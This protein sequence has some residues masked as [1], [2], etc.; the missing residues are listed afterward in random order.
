MRKGLMIVAGLFLVVGLATANELPGYGP[1]AP[2][3][4]PDRPQDLYQGDLGAEMGLGCS[5]PTGNSGGPNDCAVG[6]TCDLAPPFC[7]S[8]HYYYVFTTS[9]YCTALS[10]VCWMGGF[11]PGAEFARQPGMDWSWGGHT[12]AISPPVQVNSGYFFFGHNQPQTNCGMRWGLDTSSPSAQ[13]SFIRAPACGAYAWTL[14]D[15]LG[16]PGNWC[17]SATVDATSPVELQSWGSVKQAY[18]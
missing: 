1:V 16:F 14:L 3:N 9:I 12:V 5:N 17:Y 10:F 11:E 18:R 13:T 6:V 4:P 15:A 8:A 7:I 2:Q